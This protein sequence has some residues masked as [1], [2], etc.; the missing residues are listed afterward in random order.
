MYTS[1]RPYGRVGRCGFGGQGV[2]N[3]IRAGPHSCAYE[4]VCGHRAH[5]ACE[6]E[7][8]HTVWHMGRHWTYGRVLRGKVQSCA[9]REGSWTFARISVR[10]YICMR[11]WAWDGTHRMVYG[12]AL[13]G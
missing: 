8:G 3:G 13:D 7:I 6:P 4:S 1:A 2:T 12:S 5:G 9:K 10:T 11:V